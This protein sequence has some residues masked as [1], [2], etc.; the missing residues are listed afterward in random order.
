M[1]ILAHSI[2]AI[3]PLTLATAATAQWTESVE[4]VLG[5]SALFPEKPEARAAIYRGV[6][7]SVK[8][9]AA[10]GVFC[11][12]A[13]S[14][15][16]KPVDASAELASAPDKFAQEVGGKIS[17]TKEITVNRGTE[18]LPAVEID[19]SNNIYALRSIVVVDGSRVYQ[20]AGG[21]PA[22]GGRKSNLKRCVHGMKLIAN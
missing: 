19:V 9:A 17:S 4:P 7:Q 2:I 12:V 16:E 1:R 3:I 14:H 5:Y 21:V 22:G 10:T 15:H 18:R 20:V 8:S 6:K 13:V 11:N